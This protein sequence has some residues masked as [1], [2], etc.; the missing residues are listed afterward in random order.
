MWTY[1]FANEHGVIYTGQALLYRHN[2]SV[3]ALLEAQRILHKTASQSTHFQHQAIACHQLDDHEFNAKLHEL[4]QGKSQ[5]LADIVEDI[6]EQVDLDEWVQT[7]PKAADL[8][9]SGNDAPV[10]DL[11]NKVLAQS[12][13]SKASDIH[14]EPHDKQLLVRFRH[15]GV[16]VSVA[17]LAIELAPLVTSRIK[18]MA[19][20]DIAE[21]RLPQD[22]RFTRELAGRP[23]DVRVSL[24]PSG[25]G[26]RVVMRL[27]DRDSG[28][29][30]L[31]NLGMPDALLAAMQDLIQRPNGIILTTG[32]T[33]SGKTTTLYAC[34]QQINTEDRNIMTIED[35]V[36]YNL[37]GISQTAVHV[38]RGMTFDKGLRAILRQDPDVV[39]VGEIRD[40]ETARTAIHASQTGHLV[41]STLHTNSAV[42]AI[43]RLQDM[44]V[45]PYLISSSVI[46]VLAQ[47]LVRALCQHCCE[48]EYATRHDDV[49]TSEVV[50]YQAVGCEAC[51]HQGYQG[52][53]GVYE[54][55]QV[56]PNI[57]HLIHDKASEQSIVEQARTR[58]QSLYANGMYLVAKGITTQQEIERVC[59]GSENG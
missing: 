26:E 54:L 31:P 43:I 42:G 50:G 41:L 22:G 53:V 36:E 47:R 1:S 2:T 4:F 23:V 56:T 3:E 49:S 39:M 11:I 13:R 44:G 14:I 57:K 9:E 27:L 10:V 19:K 52:R 20:L 35:P 51:D 59:K 30:Q 25:V 5:A 24:I 18:I 46:A 15:D 38:K 8:A 40:L 12:I 33:N 21:T 55:L 48:P 28:S 58:N 34:L 6:G 16:L 37:A 7:I 29:L 45:E 32:P 17:H